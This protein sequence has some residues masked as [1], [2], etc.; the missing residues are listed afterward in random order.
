MTNSFFIYRM[1]NFINSAYELNKLPEKARQFAMLSVQSIRL[2]N[3]FQKLLAIAQNSSVAAF[4]F[5]PLIQFVDSVKNSIFELI[6]HFCKEF[7]A[8][9]KSAIKSFLSSSPHEIRISPAGIPAALSCS[10]FIWRWVE[11]A[12]FRQQVLASAT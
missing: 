12:G 10:S 2:C 1:A 5:F 8:C 11:V 7:N 6:Y 3:F 9:C 4:F